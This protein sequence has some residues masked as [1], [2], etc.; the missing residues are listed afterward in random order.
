MTLDTDP[1]P[2]GD[3][4]AALL[5]RWVAAW[6][7]SRGATRRR[8]GRAWLVDVRAATRAAEYF[9]A[10]PSQAE[11]DALADRASGAQDVWVTVLGSPQPALPPGL[12]P[13]T[14]AECMMTFGLPD[15][16]PSVSGS[17]PGSA[18]PVAGV[19]LEA[20][21]GVTHATITIDGEEAA[22]GQLAVVGGDAVFDR[23]STDSRFRRRGLASRVMAALTAAAVDGGATTGLLMASIDGRPLYTALGWREV[24]PLQTFRGR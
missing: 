18:D 19:D 22:R 20:I 21:D 14:H 1:A 23:I 5:D 6:A 17:A 13:V 10:L 9:I 24:A 3:D 12:E 16:A 15:P 11:I 2:A 4:L 7:V 8:V